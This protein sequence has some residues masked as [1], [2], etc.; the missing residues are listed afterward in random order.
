MKP[1]VY[2]ANAKEALDKL[3]AEGYTTDF[4]LEENCIVCHQGKFNHDEFEITAIYR[5]EG[6]SNPDDESTVYAIESKSGLKGTLVTSYGAY[7]E[8]LSDEILKKLKG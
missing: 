6:D 7:S 1:K 5:Y 2:Y 8:N 4:N 3:K